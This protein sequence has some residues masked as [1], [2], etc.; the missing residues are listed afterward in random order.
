M[1]ITILRH[2]SL[3]GYFFMDY[4]HNPFKTKKSINKSHVYI[5]KF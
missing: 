5:V 2:I 3:V 1:K 4:L